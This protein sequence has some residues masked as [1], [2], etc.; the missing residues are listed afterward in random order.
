VVVFFLQQ[1]IHFVTRQGKARVHVLELLL[2]SAWS[3]HS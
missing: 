2:S 1:R 3:L